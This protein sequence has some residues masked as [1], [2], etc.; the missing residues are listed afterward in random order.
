VLLH[1][2]PV[3]AWRIGC[4]LSIPLRADPQVAVVPVPAA[5]VVTTYNT[6]GTEHGGKRGRFSE[7]G[8]PLCHIKWVSSCKR[9]RLATLV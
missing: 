5:V 2:L 1:A 7:T 6:L 4:L 9:V 3:H 8:S